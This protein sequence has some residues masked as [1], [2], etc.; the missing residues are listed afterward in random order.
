[1][2]TDGLNEIQKQAAEQKEGP[3]LIVAGAGSGKTRTLTF[4]IAHLLEIG[5]SPYSVMALTFTNKAAKEMQ[6][7]ITDLVGVAAK[8][9]LM[10]TFHSIFSRIL[11][12][13]GHRIGYSS[14]YTIYDDDDSK[15][16]I[17]SIIK[18]LNLDDKD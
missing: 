2:I 14:S 12:I 11:R 15:K 7:R 8:S 18:E 4:R 9:I 13:D 5:V 6:E 17:G 16:L 10:G 3:I 1:M